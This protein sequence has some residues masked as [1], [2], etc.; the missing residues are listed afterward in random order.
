MSF[1]HL[2]ASLA[3]LAAMAVMTKSALALAPSPT[4][5][6]APGLPATC[7]TTTYQD[8]GTVAFP[9]FCQSVERAL[10]RNG[11]FKAALQRARRVDAV[12]SFAAL[13]SGRIVAI[14]LD[15]SSGNVLIDRSLLS[16]LNAVHAP[17]NGSGTQ[18]FAMPVSLRAV[19]NSPA[20]AYHVIVK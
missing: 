6:A 10:L 14:L 18:I 19:D 5:I 11:P 17:A 9:A 12:I 1:K 7:A 8:Q 13:P 16:S 15:R 3:V 4:V 2:S 20:V